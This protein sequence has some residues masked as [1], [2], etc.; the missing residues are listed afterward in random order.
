[1]SDTEQNLRDAISARLAD[2]ADITGVLVGYVVVAEVYEADGER[3][4]V[5][6]SSEDSTVWARIGMLDAALARNRHDFI[7]TTDGP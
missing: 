6:T 5:Q 2:D 4:L 1:M 7:D 3:S